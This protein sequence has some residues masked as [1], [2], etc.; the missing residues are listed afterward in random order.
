MSNLIE[1][2]TPI[3]TSPDSRHHVPVPTL[4][5]NGSTTAALSV[6]GLTYEGGSKEGQKSYTG[7]EFITIA[8]HSKYG[9]LLRQFEGEFIPGQGNVFEAPGVGVI[10]IRHP[11]WWKPSHCPFN[12][13]LLEDERAELISRIQAGFVP[14]YAISL[15][16][17]AIRPLETDRELSDYG[18]KVEIGTVGNEVEYVGVMEI[19]GEIIPVDI[20]ALISHLEGSDVLAAIEG[21]SSQVE[22]A[23]PHREQGEDMV[24]YQSRIARHAWMLKQI[25]NK[26]GIKLLPLGVIPGDGF[27][28]P[29]FGNPHVRNVLVRG[30]SAALGKDLDVEEAADM[31][32]GFGTNGLHINV[33]LQRLKDNE[34]VKFVGDERAYEVGKLTNPRVKALLKAFTLNGNLNSVEVLSSGALSIREQKRKN[35]ATARVG[36]FG[37]FSDCYEGFESGIAPSVQRAMLGK[38]IEGKY[39]PASTVHNPA[40]RLKPDIIETTIFDAEPNLEKI[41]WVES[42]LN[43]YVTSI[44]AAILRDSNDPRHIDNVMVG[45]TDSQREFFL[46]MV[47]D[48]GEWD[49]LVG[50]IDTQG[51][52]AEIIWNGQVTKVSK[53]LLEFI[54]WVRE[55]ATS[56]GLDANNEVDFAHLA[57]LENSLTCTAETFNQYFNVRDGEGSDRFGCG[58]IAEVSRTIFNEL[59]ASGR[60]TEQQAYVE[61]IKAYNNAWNVYMDDFYARTNILPFM[62]EA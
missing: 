41:T 43:L 44:D 50:L 34:G 37:R 52:K 16:K 35:L 36:E 15:T 2:Q 29:N 38:I 25:C 59:I 14:E 7:E 49:Y 24:Q 13:E 23:Y 22:Q 53:V 20:Q 4:S 9:E 54:S 11:R 60:Y 57:Q 17:V 19:D 3:W 27:G 1:S 39:Y 47:S 30:M 8:A 42:L 21:F 61:V 51:A 48:Q 26:L 10:E 5:A 28:Q 18:N 6:M 12:P 45:M 58:S 40:G 31:L 56:Q 33:G 62:T 55:L 46:G 32:A